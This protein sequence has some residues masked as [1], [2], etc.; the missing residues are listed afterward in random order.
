[1]RLRRVQTRLLM[2]LAMSGLASACTL[3]TP[4]IEHPLPDSLAS[5][6]HPNLVTDVR[7]AP[8]CVGPEDEPDSLVAT[9]GARETPEAELIGRIMMAKVRGDEIFVLDDQLNVVHVLDIASRSHVRVG[10]PGQGPGEL[11]FPRGLA[12]SEDR[13]YV[14]DERQNIHVFARMDG[15][16]SW[17]RDIPVPFFPMDICFMDDGLYLLA[18]SDEASGFIHRLE[19]DDVVASFGISYRWDNPL[20]RYAT[21][22]GRLACLPEIGGIAWVPTRLNEVHM[23]GTDGALRWITRLPGHWPMGIVENAA[24]GSVAMGLTPGRAEMHMLYAVA[25]VAS[26][27]LVQLSLYDQE[28]VDT[29]APKMIHSYV[30][31][32]ISGAVGEIDFPYSGLIDWHGGRMALFANGPWP[33][34]DVIAVSERSAK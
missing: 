7:D 26:H 8:A 20:I 27:L 19:Q 24:S 18:L 31:A 9:F 5:A 29:D 30:I 23:Y 34:V 15:Q 13:I 10:R 4:G 1:M 22:E 32:P 11:T 2:V 3:E 33:K 6:F 14:A 25:P 17:T 16:W 28:A 21:T 12:L